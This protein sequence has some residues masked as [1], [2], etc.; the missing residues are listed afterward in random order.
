MSLSLITWKV[1]SSSQGIQQR[2]RCYKRQVIKIP[3]FSSGK[4]SSDK[5]TAVVGPVPGPAQEPVSFLAAIT[6][7]S[8]SRRG[9][10]G[11]VDLR[12]GWKTAHGAPLVPYMCYSPR[13]PFTATLPP[14]FPSPQVFHKVPPPMPL[15]FNPTSTKPTKPQFKARRR[16]FIHAGKQCSPRS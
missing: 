3:P 8:L 5:P 9:V 13:K 12:R 2:K 4:G 10:Q 11:A 1:G 14:A 15:A 7:S 16:P 6:P